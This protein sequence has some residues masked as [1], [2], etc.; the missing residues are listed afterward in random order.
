MLFSAGFNSYLTA[1]LSIVISM[2]FKSSAKLP[3][4]CSSLKALIPIPGKM[5]WGIFFS[6][7]Q[8]WVV[9]HHFKLAMKSIVKGLFTSHLLCHQNKDT[10]I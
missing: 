1:N 8:Y 2:S 4:Q 5:F 10:A 9:L 7:S 6:C 3:M